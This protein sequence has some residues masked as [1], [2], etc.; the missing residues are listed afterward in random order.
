MIEC[1]YC[2]EDVPFESVIQCSGDDDTAFYPASF[3]P[4]SS[5][6]IMP[7]SSSHPHHYH[8]HHYHHHYHTHYHHHYHTHHHNYHARYYYYH[9]HHHHEYHHHHHHH[10]YAILCYYHHH[11]FFR[12]ASVLQGLSTEV[13]GATIIWKWWVALGADQL[14]WLWSLGLLH[15]YNFHM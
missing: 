9:H 6:I 13:C 15:W 1:G 4:T 10:K 2:Y 7:I 8:H 5:I 14:W 11:S 12:G 3:A